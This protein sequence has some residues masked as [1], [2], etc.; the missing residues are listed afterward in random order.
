M[1]FKMKY[2]PNKK[3]GEGFPYKESPNKFLGKLLKKAAGG[4]VGL[5]GG[6]R[7]GN[8]AKAGLFGGLGMLGSHVFGK[9]GGAGDAINAARTGASAAGNVDEFDYDAAMN[10]SGLA[11]KDKP[12]DPDDKETKK[13]NL[14]KNK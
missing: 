1:A 6:K 10:P 13:K 5:V 2:N 12:A 14:K 3:T 9:R 11:K 4:A 7:I 8:L